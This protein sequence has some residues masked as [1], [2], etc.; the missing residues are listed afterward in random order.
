MSLHPDTPAEEPL[1]DDHRRWLSA[2]ADGEADALDKACQAWRDGPEARAHWHTVH[3]IGD[4]MRSTELAAQPAHDAAFLARL[5][6]RLAAEPVVLAPAPR[7]AP[8]VSVVAPRRAAAAWRSAAVAAGLV[9][10][11]GVLVVSRMSEPTPSGT[12]PLAQADA[13]RPVSAPLQQAP[14]QQA[15]GDPTLLRDARLD[16]FLRAHQAARG[17]MAVAVPGS[18]LRRV[19]TELPA[20]ASR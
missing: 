14:L 6:E 11:A 8:A 1:S 20:G 12:G 3:L 15:Q 4:V 17:G 2:A 9:A 5:R 16:E 10:V 7:P 19:D 13:P 18:G